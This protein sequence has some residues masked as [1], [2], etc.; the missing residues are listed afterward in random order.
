MIWPDYPTWAHVAFWILAAV[1]LAVLVQAWRT[2]RVK[3]AARDARLRVMPA[4]R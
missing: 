3:T 2:R 1:S 4:G